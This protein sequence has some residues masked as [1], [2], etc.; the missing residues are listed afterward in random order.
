MQRCSVNEMKDVFNE[1]LNEKKARNVSRYWEQKILG[2]NQIKYEH[3]KGGSISIVKSGSDRF[4]RYIVEIQY[5]NGHS[6]K[7]IN[8]DKERMVRLLVS[9]IKDN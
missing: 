1:I 6:V 3:E 2:N 4:V 8:K 9:H 5:K 7:K